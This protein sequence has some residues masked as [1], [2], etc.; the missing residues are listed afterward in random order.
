MTA[1]KRRKPKFIPDPASG[2]RAVMAK[3][4]AGHMKKI[5]GG[6]VTLEKYGK[7]YF[8]ELGKR[9]GRVPRV[10]PG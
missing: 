6:R 1:K 5:A 9:G 8:S 4:G 7:L 2:G 3:Y 10:K